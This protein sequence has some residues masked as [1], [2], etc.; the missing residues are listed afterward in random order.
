[1]DCGEAPDPEA[2]REAFAAAHERAYGYRDEDGEVELVTL[3]VTATEPGPEI[4]AAAAG[5]S[6][7]GATRSARRAWFDGAEH[8]AAVLTGEPEP[9][10]ELSGPAICEL[11]EAT[12][13]VPP[14]WAGRVEPSG[15]IRLERA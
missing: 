7:S 10:T 2:L 15:T 12:L 9:G 1:M 4:D 14:G 8:D 11:P 6:G 5:A 13:A 3:R